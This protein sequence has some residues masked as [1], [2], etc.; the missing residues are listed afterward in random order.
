MELEAMEGVSYG[1]ALHQV[2]CFPF[3]VGTAGL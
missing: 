2:S 1:G 3:V